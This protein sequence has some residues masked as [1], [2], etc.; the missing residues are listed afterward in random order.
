MIEE[1]YKSKLSK[2]RSNHSYHSRNRDRSMHS[3]KEEPE[4]IEKNYYL[5][6]AQKNHLRAM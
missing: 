3:S 1:D 6:L 4:I 5:P 2:Q